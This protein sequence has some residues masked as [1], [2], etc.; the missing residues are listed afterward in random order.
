MPGPIVVPAKTWSPGLKLVTSLPTVSIS[1]ASGTDI[2]EE[3]LSQIKIVVT[4]STLIYGIDGV[5]IDQ[6]SNYSVSLTGPD[7]DVPGEVRFADNPNV[8]FEAGMFHIL[9]RNRGDQL[10]G[11]LPIRE[12]NEFTTEV[13]FNFAG[14]R[15]LVVP[16]NKGELNEPRFVEML[17]K[18]MRRLLGF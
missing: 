10:E 7:G 4:D 9:R 5:G 18:H 14:D 13:P 3:N 11:W 6:I 2:S 15:I 12:D 8:L 1:P 17:N 16:R